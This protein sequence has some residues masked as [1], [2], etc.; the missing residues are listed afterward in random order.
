M[1]QHPTLVYVFIRVGIICALLGLSLVPI[2]GASAAVPAP[3]KLFVAP[4]GSDTNP[5]IDAGTVLQKP[6]ATLAHA[7]TKSGPGTVIYLRGGVYA[8]TA[9]IHW[10]NL[11]SGSA[12]S[13]IS[14]QPHAKEQPVLECA[15]I[16]VPDTD[17][18]PTCLKI[19]ASFSE[20]RGL[21]IKNS[22]NSGLSVLGANYVRILNNNIHHSRTQ[23]IYVTGEWGA[24]S[25][26]LIDGNRIH[27]NAQ[28]NILPESGQGGGWDSGIGIQH[29]ATNV[30]ITNNEV[31]HNHGEGI[32]ISAKASIVVRNNILHDNFSVNMYI[33]GASNTTVE[34]NFIYT[35]G[36]ARSKYFRY[37]A[38]ANGI[39]IANEHDT[40]GTAL[41][42]LVIQNNIVVGGR[43][44]F[45]YGY[46]FQN[47]PMKDTTILNNTFYSDTFYAN[48]N[49][50]GGNSAA[51]R[52]EANVN[53]HT[54]TRFANNAVV[55][56]ST[57][58]IR[59][60]ESAGISFDHNGWYGLPAS[61]A[62]PIGAGT[63]DITSDPKLVAPGQ[64]TALS[65]TVLPGS[66][67]IDAGA[68][69]SAPG[70]FW[71]TTRPQ[72]GKPDIGA[73][74]KEAFQPYVIYPTTGTQACAMA[75]GDF[76]NDAREDVVVADCSAWRLDL[77]LAR[78]DGTLQPAIAMPGP[79]Q[80]AGLLAKDLNGDGKLDLVVADHSTTSVKIMLGNGAGGFSAASEYFMTPY[81]S[82]MTSGDFNGDG[83]VDLAFGD[84]YSEGVSVLLNTGA[85]Q[86]PSEMRYL[87]DPVHWGLIVQSGDINRDNRLDLIIGIPYL[88]KVVIMRGVGNGTFQAPTSV[89]TPLQSLHT[90]D[91]NKD[92]YVDLII[93]GTKILWG[94]AAATYNTSSP[95]SL[96]TSIGQLTDTNADSHLDV[97]GQ[98]SSTWTHSIVRISRGDGLGGFTNTVDAKMPPNSQGVGMADINGDGRRDLISLN[99]NS[100][101]VVIAAP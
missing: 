67:L 40:S 28:R 90:G 80:P 52:I 97:V 21:E 10:Q 46:Y 45:Y 65:Y 53:S 12:S 20:I 24:S 13:W 66:L 47:T 25:N 69:P 83:K 64:W 23:G 94:S 87:L 50:N 18:P 54:N 77:F 86:F 73:H 100:I 91:I 68:S 6:Y 84:D 71:G 57:G 70:D 26:V 41:S 34:N 8:L 48:T 5:D 30:Q 88:D 37:N 59:R 89:A 93:S 31:Y 9:P 98:L 3:P 27:E 1:S 19:S 96:T 42:K 36:P 62:S 99:G 101:S 95:L 79:M 61:P 29:Q 82:S 56:K 49:A 72:A 35:E 78:A 60:I 81:T 38:P 15:S 2:H 75:S 7:I 43:F 92:G 11:Y 17:N 44:A 14:V 51:V 58:A 63:G 74:E 85:G 4:G 55:Q 76:N 33:N 32:G 39:A 16:P 22:P